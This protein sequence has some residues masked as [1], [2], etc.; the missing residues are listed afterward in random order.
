MNA[1]ESKFIKSVSYIFLPTAVHKF[2]FVCYVRTPAEFWIAQI[3]G[4]GDF[5]SAGDADATSA[6]LSTF[7]AGLIKL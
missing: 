7:E 3:D 4:A 5:Q 2:L 1:E 6:H